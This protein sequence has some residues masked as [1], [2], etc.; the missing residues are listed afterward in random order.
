[1]LR[2]QARKQLIEGMLTQAI[3]P[4]S[5]STPQRLR[6]GVCALLFVLILLAPGVQAAEAG[7]DALTGPEWKAGVVR[8][9]PDGRIRLDTAADNSLADLTNGH[10]RIGLGSGF[11]VSR[12]GSVVTNQHVIARCSL[13]TIETPWKAVGVA[14]LVASDETRDLALLRTDVTARAA[15][16]FSSNGDPGP[17]DPLTVVGYP[18]LKL[19]SLLPQ[20]TSAIHAGPVQGQSMIALDAAVAPGSSGGPVLDLAG[21]L[22]AVIRGEINTPAVY[23]KTGRVIRD[24]AFA[25]PASETEQFLRN[26]GIAVTHSSDPTPL[27][28]SALKAL[29][30]GTVTR[31]G[32]W[33]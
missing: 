11:F 4:S 5:T 15:V 27:S 26:Q 9:G 33:K 2:L 32:C 23:K 28:Q 22:G 14:L 20:V 31:I 3:C 16:A 17:G 24:I 10:R 30:M 25:I 8:R 18:T 13:I 19:P 7:T 1:V 6:I 29:V 12:D 21:R